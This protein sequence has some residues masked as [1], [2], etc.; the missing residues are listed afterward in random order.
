MIGPVSKIYPNPA[1]NEV[2][3]EFDADQLNTDY[4]LIIINAQGLMVH[5]L[6]NVN[7]ELRSLAELLQAY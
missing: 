5:H 4:E 1:G 7:C 2:Y 3:F 6:S